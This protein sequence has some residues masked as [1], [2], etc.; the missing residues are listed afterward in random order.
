MLLREQEIGTGTGPLAGNHYVTLTFKFIS[1]IGAM[2]QHRKIIA[3]RTLASR[4][5]GLININV[6]VIVIGAV[7]LRHPYSRC[8]A[9]SSHRVH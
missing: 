1:K 2:E 4:C 3:T 7:T 5:V 8:N 9:H 6:N